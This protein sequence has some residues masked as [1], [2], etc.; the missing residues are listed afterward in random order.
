MMEWMHSILTTQNIVWMCGM[1]AILIS[2]LMQGLTKRFKPWSYL[3]KQIGKAVN[4]EML[5]KLDNMQKQIENLEKK[6]ERQDRLR[7]KTEA[8]AARRRIL[9]FADEVR[10]KEKH[11]EEYFN[12]VL[13]DISDYKE[14]CNTH[15]EFEN[16]KAAIA[17]RIVGEAYT[18]CVQTDAFL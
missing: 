3:A 16:E 14:Y 11:S 7:D 13:E 17:I 12:N 5:D 15:P 18:H 6:N 2:T 10:R 4:G 9:Q 1:V 8:L